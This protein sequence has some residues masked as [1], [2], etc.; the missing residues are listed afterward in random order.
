[1]IADTNFFID[2]MRTRSSSHAR[3]L[4][5]LAEI[6]E[7]GGHVAMTAITRFELASGVEQSNTSA[8]ERSRVASLLAAYATF[9]L[10][11]P[12]AD[13]AGAIRDKLQRAGKGI[14]VADALIAAITLLSGE[15][16]LTRNVREFS[17]VE[18]LSLS[19]Y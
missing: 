11:G 4:A 17:R 19:E 5:K 3:A 1:M 7:R 14:G 10:E 18:G 8:A 2:L 15:S 9:P 6:E 12:A 16:L 13:L